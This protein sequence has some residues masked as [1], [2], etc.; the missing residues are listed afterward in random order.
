MP[1]PLTSRQRLNVTVEAWAIE[2]V[3]TALIIAGVWAIG[4]EIEGLLGPDALFLDIVKVR[5]FPELAE[6]G[7]LLRLAVWA[8]IG[9]KKH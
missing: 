3:E 1:R 8:T 9:R 6:M 4:K 7:S 5:Y 2:L